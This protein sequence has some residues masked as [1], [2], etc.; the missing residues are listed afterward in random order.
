MI[1]VHWLPANIIK[2]EQNKETNEK[3]PSIKHVN[4]NVF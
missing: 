1:R 4:A 2:H 3:M